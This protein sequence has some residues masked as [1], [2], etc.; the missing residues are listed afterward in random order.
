MFFELFQLV[1]RGLEE[2]SVSGEQRHDRLT[3]GNE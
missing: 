1:K 2:F 3:S